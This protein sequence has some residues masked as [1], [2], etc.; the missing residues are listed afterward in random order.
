MHFS[1]RLE[2][3]L[4]L[5]Q[6]SPHCFQNECTALKFW[7]TFLG[8]LLLTEK[9]RM[10]KLIGVE[11]RKWSLCGFQNITDTRWK[12]WSGDVI[13]VTMCCPF[14]SSWY[15]CRDWRDS[16]I[17]CRNKTEAFSHYSFIQPVWLRAEMSL[18]AWTFRAPIE[19]G[20]TSQMRWRNS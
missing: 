15:S 7:K 11:I 8:I 1:F 9:K 16:R 19:V 6:F 13:V 20:L 10:R 4:M 17:L 14:L 18:H 2:K 5:A 12:G 3:Q